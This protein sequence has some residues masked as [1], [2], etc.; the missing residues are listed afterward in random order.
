DLDGKNLGLLVSKPGLHAITF[1]WSVRGKTVPGGFHFELHLPS[2]PLINV[3][4]ELPENHVLSVPRSGALL[5]GPYATKQPGKRSWKLSL[6]GKAQL[7]LDIRT[8]AGSAALPYSQ[9]V[10]VDTKQEITP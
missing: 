5:S 8:P 2:C 3:E 1:D 7:Q 9:L 6:T 10:Q 4:I